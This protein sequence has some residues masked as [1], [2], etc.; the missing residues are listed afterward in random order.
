MRAIKI[1][2]RNLFAIDRWNNVFVM[3][4]SGTFRII[5]KADLFWNIIDSN[6]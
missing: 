6:K 3:D 1:H 2:N 4:S 5:S